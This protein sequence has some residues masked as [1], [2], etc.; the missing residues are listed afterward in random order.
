MHHFDAEAGASPFRK[1]YFICVLSYKKNSKFE[2]VAVVLFRQNNF[3]Q[4]NSKALSHDAVLEE[5]Y[6]Q[7]PKKTTPPKNC[8]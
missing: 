2:I 1:I 4:E 3:F 8:S 5:K 6:A 7:D